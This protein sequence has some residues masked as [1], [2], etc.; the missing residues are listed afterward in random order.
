MVVVLL[1]EAMATAATNE[2]ERAP[3]SAP[4]WLMVEIM[5]RKRCPIHGESVTLS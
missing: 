5:E 1:M 2:C 3:Y 4:M